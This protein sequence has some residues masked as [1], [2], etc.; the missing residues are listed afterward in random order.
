[1]KK[2][3]GSATHQS[4]PWD[5]TSSDV[6]TSTTALIEALFAASELLSD[7]EPDSPHAFKVVAIITKLKRGLV[8]I[9]Q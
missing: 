5:P 2:T 6:D 9:P 1:M 3:N 4:A 7:L 8:F